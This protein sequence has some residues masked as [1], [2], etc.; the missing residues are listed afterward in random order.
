[1]TQ[2]LSKG[3]HVWARVAVISKLYAG[4]WKNWLVNQAHA[5]GCWQAI[6]SSLAA[7]QKHQFLA[8][9]ATQGSS[10]NGRW[11]PSEDMSSSPTWNPKPFHSVTLKVT[12]RHFC[13]TYGSKS[14]CPAML[15]GGNDTQAMRTR[16]Q[17]HWCHFRSSLPH[18]TL[19][20]LV[21]PVMRSRET[22]LQS[23]EGSIRAGSS[24]TELHRQ[25]LSFNHR[26]STPLHLSHSPW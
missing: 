18:L 17:G 15:R 10:Q 12:S 22:G 5:H 19:S 26:E 4:W 2:D 9:R 16:R 14:L 24:S 11:F 7:G 1:M 21:N 13:H 25:S 6:R 3:S 8:A 23:R 20:Q